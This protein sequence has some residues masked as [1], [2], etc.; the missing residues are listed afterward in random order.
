MQHKVVLIGDPG[1]DTAFA[2]ALALFDRHLQVLAL[3]P[4]AGNVPAHQAT[5]NTHTL[6]AQ[7][8]PPRWPRL[9][10]ALPIQYEIDG[11]QLHGAD[12]LG[13][14]RFPEVSLHAPMPSDRL[15]VEMVQEYPDELTIICMGPLT[16][17][18]SALHREPGLL[19]RVRRVIILGGAWRE[20]GNAT[21]A[22]EFHFYCDPEAAREVL[23]VGLPIT[24]VPLDVMR[25]IIF[26]PADLLELP[27]AT[28]RVS[29]FLRHILPFGIRATSNLYGIEGFHLKD[30]LGIA[31]LILP[32]AVTTRSIYVDVETRGEIT[33]GMSLFDPR[34][35]GANR[36]NVELVTHVDEK[37]VRD[38]IFSTLKQ[39]SSS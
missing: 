29:R 7:L 19:R 37:A 21:L 5:V 17:L 4:T 10:A 3:A 33:R 1:I 26:S 6:V 9:G 12:G 14:A 15:I 16:T 23:H 27:A 2:T 18:Q 22:A 38:Y 39:I 36:P 30:V 28:C 11:R 20:P 8:D 25:K 34:V 35:H 31:T 13:N 32:H 24:L